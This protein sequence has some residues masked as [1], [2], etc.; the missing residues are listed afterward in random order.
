MPAPYFRDVKGS[1]L[2]AAEGDENVRYLEGLGNYRSPADGLSAEQVTAIPGAIAKVT[3]AKYVAM[4]RNGE[5]VYFNTL[6]EA[7]LSPIGN[8]WSLVIFDT[9][10]EIEADIPF[11]N[12]ETIQGNGCKI[13]PNGHSWVLPH[14]LHAVRVVGEGRLI[15]K[16]SRSYGMTGTRIFNSVLMQA[17][18]VPNGNIFRLH[19]TTIADD[20]GVGYVW[21]EGAGTIEIE[22]GCSIYD[23]GAHDS[24]TNVKKQGAGGIDFANPVTTTQ[25]ATLQANTAYYVTGSGYTLTLPDPTERLGGSIFVQ[26]ADTATG[27]YPVQGAGTLSLYAGETMNLRATLAGW[28]QTGG[29]L[30]PMIARLETSTS[31][32]NAL[33][34]GNYTLIPYS[35]A[36]SNTGPATL[37]DVPGSQIVVQRAATA[38]LLATAVIR[39]YTGSGLPYFVLEKV[40]GSTAQTV[41]AAYPVVSSAGLGVVSVSAQTDVQ[42]LDR[43]RFRVYTPSGSSAQLHGE[44]PDN[45][46][47]LT[48]TEMV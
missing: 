12:F 39:N 1:P 22:A 18:L 14:N 27:L 38:S 48:Y 45:V 42:P 5:T 11:N 43:L 41:G 9:N 44:T 7:L 23:E 17:T 3:T 26:V 10:P 28:K 37:V 24:A 20:N 47:S 16:P 15:A 6:T 25:A 13:D 33:A 21:S 4:R 29:K 8:M 30:L 2:S 40:T 35:V 19:D 46:C 36:K 31:Q 32:Q 34:S